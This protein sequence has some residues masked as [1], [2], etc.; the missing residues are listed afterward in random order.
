[1]GCIVFLVIVFMIGAYI[2]WQGGRQADEMY[3]AFLKERGHYEEFER[4]LREKCG[5]QRDKNGQKID[6]LT[7][8]YIEYSFFSGESDVPPCDDAKD[9]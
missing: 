9:D 4:W 2:F 6:K 5:G 7:R 1:M 8:E 3:E